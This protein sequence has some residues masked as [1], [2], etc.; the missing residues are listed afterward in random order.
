LLIGKIRSEYP[1]FSTLNIVSSR[2]LSTIFVSNLNETSSAFEILYILK[3]LTPNFKKLTIVDNPIKPGLIQKCCFVEYEN[4]HAAKFALK[5]INNK[6]ISFQN[7]C[8]SLLFNKIFVRISADIAHFCEPLVDMIKESVYKTSSFF[9]ENFNFKMNFNIFKFRE[10]LEQFGVLFSLRLYNEKILVQYDSIMSTGIKDDMF[11]FEGRKFRAVPAIKP[12]KNIE[13]YRERI[14]KILPNQLLED[15]RQIIISRFAENSLILNE[16][17]KKKAENV[18]TKL[19]DNEFLINK[20]NTKNSNILN[21]FLVE[22]KTVRKRKRS[23]SIEDNKNNN[24][25]FFGEGNKNMERYLS[26]KRNNRSFSPDDKSSKKIQNSKNHLNNLGNNQNV[27]NNGNNYNNIANNNHQ[28][29]NSIPFQLLTSLGLIASVSNNNPSVLNMFQQLIQSSSNSNIPQTKPQPLMQIQTNSVSNSSNQQAQQHNSNFN[30]SQINSSYNFQHS[31]PQYT[32][33]MNINPQNINQNMTPTINNP[34]FH[35][36]FANVQYNNELVS[37]G[38][39]HN[40]NNNLSQIQGYEFQE[41]DINNLN[42]LNNIGGINTTNY[43]N[44]N[45]T[46]DENLK[47]YFQNFK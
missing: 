20:K 33:N 1:E 9:V 29:Q 17:I 24:L 37:Q 21:K 28:I 13:K 45:L 7:N 39:F 41:N 15:D 18:A 5:V 25:N 27:I 46:F 31:F 2:Y 35:S 8:D 36:P 44:Q 10:F 22:P 32:Q 6:I 43:Q 4:F 19:I 30:S 16:V 40:N 12:S 23:E 14:V 11:F 26:S 47:K 34:N 42:S 38:Y 3:Q